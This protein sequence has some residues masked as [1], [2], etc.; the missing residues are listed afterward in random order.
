MPRTRAEET[1]ED[2]A[3]K[4]SIGRRFRELRDARDLSLAKLAARLGGIDSNNLARLERGESW[5]SVQLLISVC[6]ELDGSADHLLFGKGQPPTAK[7]GARRPFELRSD[8]QPPPRERMKPKVPVAVAAYL[9]REGANLRP[10]VAAILRDA[11]YVALGLEEITP[12]EVR[13]FVAALDVDP[14]QDDHH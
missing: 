8:S 4:A 12:E 13:K 14:G 1:P 10:E 11:D 6:L 3:L 2:V 9:A 7:A 5:P